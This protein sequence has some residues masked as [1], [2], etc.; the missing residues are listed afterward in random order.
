MSNRDIIV[1]GASTGGL[2]VLKAIVRELPKDLPAAVFVVWH[3]S[4]DAYGLLPFVL[5]KENTLPAANAFDR[6]TIENSRIYVAPP[7]HHLLVE[8]GIMRV[9]RSPKENRFRPAV[10]PL[11]RS[12]AAAYGNRVI[13]VVLS[14]GLDDGTA[15]LWAI[16]QKGV[17]AVVQ[18]PDD[19]EARSMPENALREVDVDYCVPH[20]EIAKLLV[21]LVGE[22]LVS[23]ENGDIQKDKKLETEVKIAAGDNAFEMGIME[24][25][26]LTPFTCP[27]C[28]GTLLKLKNGNMTR[29][30]CHTGHAFSADGLLASVTENVEESIWNTIRGIEESVMLLNHLKEH[31]GEDN[32]ALAEAYSDKAGE[33]ANRAQAIREAILRHEQFSID[34]LRHQVDSISG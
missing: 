22:P 1:I 34:T 24:C 20:S 7:D 9:T 21:R 2:S 28:H 16:K 10:D 31:L 27:D 8:R 15:G 13:G 6:E 19:A 33:A 18:N 14:G 17:V 29:F 25:G 26:D 30:R 23:V 3:M 32:P 12:A 11:F 5:E 4:A